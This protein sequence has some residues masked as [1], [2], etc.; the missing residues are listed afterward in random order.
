M[1]I[2]T[3][4]LTAS[5]NESVESK[6]RKGNG[7]S[8][9]TYFNLPK[10]KEGKEYEM[11]KP[12]EGVNVID[13][14]PF[15]Y[16][17]GVLKTVKPGAIDYKL[18]VDV[19]KNIGPSGSDVLSLS[20]LGLKDPIAEE[21]TNLYAAQKTLSSQD[22]K[23]KFYNEKIKPLKSKRRCIYLVLH[24]VDGKRI[25]K[26]FETAHFSFE[27]LIAEKIEE[28]RALGEAERIFADPFVGC[29]IAIMGKK[30]TFGGHEFI[31]I[32]SIKFIDRKV[33]VAKDEESAIKLC[34]SLPALDS[35][36]NV[37]TY[38]EAKDLL[39][40]AVAMTPD[41]EIAEEEEGLS[42]DAP[43]LTVPDSSPAND[44]EDDFSEVDEEAPA[45]ENDFDED[46]LVF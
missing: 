25:P 38:D 31:K 8:R 32:S 7:S 12:E 20:S 23:D 37:K 5:Q 45:D 14:L 21:L 9:E 40:G 33:P 41:T 36:L 19:H 17:G 11:F 43:T 15:Y 22:E 30:D 29:S 42:F 34:K 44:P 46:E 26:I 13:I 24:H 39:Y 28:D 16:K 1:S 3:Q 6:D 10:N 4:Q 27:R 35:L 18:D 2:F